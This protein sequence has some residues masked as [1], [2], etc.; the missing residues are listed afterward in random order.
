M[1]GILCSGEIVKRNSQLLEISADDSVEPVNS[2]PGSY[3]HLFSL[4]GYR[5]A[6][7]I[8]SA[9]EQDIFFGHSEES[10][11]YIRRQIG[12]GYMS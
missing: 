11:I 9:D 1:F 10:N 3:T 4:N 2:F 8:G 7:L 6:M 5:N 12:S